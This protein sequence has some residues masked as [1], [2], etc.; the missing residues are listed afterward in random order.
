MPIGWD[1]REAGR[2]V[3]GRGGG[4]G[5]DAFTYGGTGSSKKKDKKKAQSQHQKNLGKPLGVSRGYTVP[6]MRTGSYSERGAQTA[7]DLRATPG[8]MGR[9]LPRYFADDVMRPA[10]AEPASIAE[11]QRYLMVAGLLKDDPAWSVWDPASQSAW[12]NVLEYANARGI[13]DRAA[14]MEMAQAGNAA[15]MGGPGGGGGGGGGAGGE[16]GGGRWT[17]DE[18]G[19][20]VFVEDTFVAPPLEVRVPDKKTVERAFR[21]ASIE[22]LGGSLSAAEISEMADMYMWKVMQPQADAYRGQVANLEAEFYGRPPPNPVVTEVEAMSPEA[23]AEEEIKRR[24]PAGFDAAT[25]AEDY[26]P[27][28]F[29]TL[30]AGGGLI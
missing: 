10:N 17:L 9:Q 13:S 5:D 18:N 4:G 7:A 23:F 6:S 28:F 12:R 20:P 22:L 3:G 8:T 19:N 25:I 21:T 2:R 16:A 29:Q 11:V 24:D 30:G 14:L 26:A 1:P 15:G 27:A